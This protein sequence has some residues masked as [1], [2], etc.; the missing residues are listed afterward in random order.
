M[1]PAPIR[2]DTSN[3]FAHHTMTVRVHGTIQDIL[4]RNADYP[5][6]IQKALRDLSAEIK[7]DAPIPM[8]S[9]F[10]PDTPLWQSALDQHR[11][12]TWLNTVWFFAETYFYRQIMERVRWWETGRDP[13]TPNKLEEYASPALWTLMEAALNLGGS[14]REKL[15]VGLA[16]AL[17]GNRIDL[18]FAASR[19]H[20]T[21][22]SMDDLIVD[23][24]AQAVD[25][26]L[27]GRG[28]VHLI[29][30]NAGTELAM[31]VVLIDRLLAGVADEV[32]VHLKMHPTFVSDAIVADVWAFLQILE[33]RGELYAAL[34][35][36]LRA[37]VDSGRLRL[38]PNFF[39]NSPYFLWDLPSGMRTGFQ[40]ARLVIVKGDANYRRVVGDAVWPADAPFAEAT[41]YF[42]A[43]LLTLR[44]LK[45]DPVV[46]LP[47]NMAEALDTLDAAWRV[48][49]RRGVIQYAGGER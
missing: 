47:A 15:E 28:A 8:L 39:W 11:H 13:F 46:G 38:L 36:R 43:P 14:P 12:D 42:P 1:R 21:T 22:A 24:A 25:Q 7:A 3:A 26:L 44:T 6:S 35:Q 33:A 2:T 45:S 30:D 49:G 32:V 17:W 18:S 5:D 23:N 16:Q 34:S 20:G 27:H 40:S 37:A 41:S 48:N 10:A 4:D 9:P 31:D 29:T 19:E